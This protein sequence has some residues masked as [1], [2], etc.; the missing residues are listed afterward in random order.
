MEGADFGCGIEISID[1]YGSDVM[2]RAYSQSHSTVEP[3]IIKE[4]VIIFL[5]EWDFSVSFNTLFKHTA[6]RQGV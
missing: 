2:L 6:R 5:F 4:I 1:I 3:R